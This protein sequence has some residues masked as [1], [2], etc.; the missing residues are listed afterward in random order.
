MATNTA[1]PARKEQGKQNQSPQNGTQQ[2]GEEWQRNIAE[3]LQP[4]MTKLQQQMTQTATQQLEPIR[5]RIQ[6][7]TAQQLGGQFQNKPQG[8]TQ[9]RRQPRPEGEEAAD[10]QPRPEQEGAASQTQDAAR[11]ETAPAG[12]EGRPGGEDEQQ[13]FAPSDE[14]SQQ[15]EGTQQ[16]SDASPTRALTPVSGGELPV[17]QRQAGESAFQRWGETLEGLALIVIAVGEI[18]DGAAL[19]LQAAAQMRDSGASSRQ[20][21]A[22]GASPQQEQ[23]DGAPS[24]PQARDSSQEE[25][26]QEA[27]SQEEQAGGESLFGKISDALSRAVSSL[28]E[29]VTHLASSISS[30]G[31]QE[32]GAALQQWG[33]VLEH[34]AALLEALGSALSAKK[35]LSSLPK[36]GKVLSSGHSLMDDVKQVLGGDFSSGQKR[37]LSPL[38]AVGSMASGGG[39]SS[40]KDKDDDSGGISS[41]LKELTGGSSSEKEGGEKKD[42]GGTSLVDALTGEDS[43]LQVLR[44]FSKRQQGPGGLAPKGPI[45]RKPPPGPLRRD[46]LPGERSKNQ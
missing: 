43:P 9:Q 36:W 15:N 20:E 18:L 7:L 5:E 32:S 4:I 45:G 16:K 8:Q 21:Q 11:Q 10:N 33:K 25:Q 6:R 31:E 3:A 27:A 24:K 29:G 40:Q 30:L 22:G 34:A 19:L 13:K 46:R 39:S 41:A 23:Q 26:G 2:P 1:P 38:K 14:E 42:G 12:A 28:K 44:E 35:G 17:E 37:G